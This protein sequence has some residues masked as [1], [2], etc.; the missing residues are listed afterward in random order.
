MRQKKDKKV[1]YRVVHEL[2]LF[3]NVDEE[4][5]EGD[6]FM[7]VTEEVFFKFCRLLYGRQYD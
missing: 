7:E 3:P 6:L 5:I 4:P 1:I 2:E